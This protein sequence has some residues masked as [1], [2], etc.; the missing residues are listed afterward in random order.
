[1]A[2]SDWCDFLRITSDLGKRFF[3]AEVAL[4]PYACCR[5]THTTIDALRD[6]LCTEKI[7]KTQIK[8]VKVK[9]FSELVNNFAFYVPKNIVDAQFS[10]PF[11]VAMELCGYPLDRG[12]QESTFCDEKVLCMAK[13]VTM[14][15][16]RQAEKLF[17]KERRMPSTVSIEMKDGKIFTSRSKIPKGDPLRK[18]TKEEIQ[19]KF[20]NLVQP[21]LGRERTENLLNGIEHLEDMKNV[22]FFD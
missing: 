10:L 12:I 5:W 2:G 8:S 1:M 21:I 19:I 3:I 4:K 18:L 16:D 9:T 17:V 20:C 11:L 7:K 6:L 13:K 22:A 14:E 15:L